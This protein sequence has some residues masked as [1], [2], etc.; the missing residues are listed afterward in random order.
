MDILQRSKQSIYGLETQLTDIETN[1]STNTSDIS[2]LNADSATSGSVANQ[3]LTNNELLL[4]A[5]TVNAIVQSNFDG[6]VIPVGEVLYIRGNTDLSTYVYS[7]V[8]SVVLEENAYN[9]FIIVYDGSTTTIYINARVTTSHVESLLATYPKGYDLI[10]LNTNT[11]AAKI[12]TLLTESYTDSI[13]TFSAQGFM[14]VLDKATNTFDALD[15]SEFVVIYD[16]STF[17]AYKQQKITIGELQTRM[18][19]Q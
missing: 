8:L 9:T 4:S 13:Q 2:L 15:G 19:L 16:G 3:I 6:I 10:D 17:S 18:V 5:L 11:I 7:G 12:S 1:I 14:T